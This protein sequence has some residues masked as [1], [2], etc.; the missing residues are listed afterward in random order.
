MRAFAEAFFTHFGARVQPHPDFPAEL[1]VD[2]SPDLEAAFGR[3]RLYLVFPQAGQDPPDL[4]P[5]EDVMV[6]GSR[7]FDKMMALLAGRGEIVQLRLPGHENGSPPGTY[8][9]PLPLANCRLKTH[10]AEFKPERFF[11]VNY[12]AVFVSDERQETVMTVVLDETGQPRPELAAS[13]ATLPGIGGIEP[14]FS[15]TPSTRRKVLTRAETILQT[16]V[17]ERL[18]GLEA[19][20]QPRLQKSLLRLKS[21]YHRLIEEI[22]VETPEAAAA[23]RAGLERDL[24]RQVAGELER[25][26][27]RVTLSPLSYALVELPLVY[28]HALL[29]TAHSRQQ[30]TIIQNLYHQR[31]ENLACEHCHEPLEQLALCDRGHLVHPHCFAGCT[32][33]GRAVC[34]TCGIHPCAISG[35]MVCIDCTTRCGYC[36][37]WLSNQ[38]VE[39]CAICETPH[40]PDHRLVCRWCEQSY[41][42]ACMTAGVCHTCGQA[43]GE[44]APASPTGPNLANGRRY[45]W[46]LAENRRCRVYW[47]QPVGWLAPFWSRLFVVTD[48]AGGV[49]LERKIGWWRRWRQ[50]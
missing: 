18:A 28:H 4:S 6:Y 41:C 20:I 49:L 37:R 7:I 16:Q 38:W 40:C 36:E 22:K 25:Y 9:F 44:A 5:H 24:A 2:L 46:Q 17:S 14:A 29:V 43:L 8:P 27:L 10:R 31:L 45:K 35:R 30:R 21:Y 11:V 3:P 50:T 19:G 13:L 26:R 15:V 33:C 47:G 39:P 12:R 23:V 1:I 32:Q 48:L 42:A 34:Y